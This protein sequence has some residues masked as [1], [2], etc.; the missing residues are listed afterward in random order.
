MFELPS[1]PSISQSNAL[2]FVP[3]G[4]TTR[5]TP[6]LPL[7]LTPFKKGTAAF[8]LENAERFLNYSARIF[9]LNGEPRCLKSPYY[10]HCFLKSL[11]Q[12]PPLTYRTMPSRSAN[13]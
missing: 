1:L 11:E 9:Q 13:L 12:R 3:K 7:S 8:N 5:Q 2:K 4:H 6:S 10:V